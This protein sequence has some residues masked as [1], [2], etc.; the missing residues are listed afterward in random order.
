LF[1]NVNGSVDCERDDSEVV[2]VVI[3]APG[4][5]GG[6][7]GKLSASSKPGVAFT[8]VGGGVYAINVT[9]GRADDREELLDTFLG[10]G[11]ITFT[12]R[13]NFAGDLIGDDGIKVEAIST[14]QADNVAQPP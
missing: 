4:D 11:S 14:K 5:G 3:T 1:I 12:P 10:A 13:K 9:A 8:D 2:A 7:Y 6:P